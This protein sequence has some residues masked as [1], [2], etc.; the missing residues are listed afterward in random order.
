MIKTYFTLGQQHINTIHANTEQKVWDKDGIVEVVSETAMEALDF[1]RL[2]F[3]D[4]W[5]LQ[6]G[7]DEIDGSFMECF[8]KGIVHSYTLIPNG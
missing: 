2:S 4:K 1:I 8:P 7:E 6:Y 5:G 3:G